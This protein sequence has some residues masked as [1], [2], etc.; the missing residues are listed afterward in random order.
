[1]TSRRRSFM[2]KDDVGFVDRLNEA[3]DRAN[4]T[5]DKLSKKLG[6]SR[7]AVGHWLTGKRTPSDSQL[8]KIAEVLHVTT[9]WLLR[10]DASAEVAMLQAPDWSF[11]P[12]LPGQRDYGNAN[13]WTVPADIATLVREAGQNSKDA[14]D[15]A[16]AAI[17]MQF[18]LIELHGAEA[19][20]FWE[21]AGW[22]RLRPHVEAAARTPGKLGRKLAAGLT[23]VSERP[24]R[25]FLLRIDDFGT[26]GLTGPEAGEGSFAAL[27]RNNLDSFKQS[28][29]AGGS[30]GL[31]KAAHWRCSDISTVFFNTVTAERQA[32]VVARSELTYHELGPTPSEHHAGPG[33]FGVEG[34]DRFAESV[35]DPE[36]ARQLHLERDTL[37]DDLRSLVASE[38]GTSILIAAFQN[39]ASEIPDDP[40][41]IAEE[42]ERELAVNFFPAIRAKKLVAIVE[43]RVGDHLRSRKIV[44]PKQY[45]PDFC[46]LYDR[47]ASGATVD[48]F[49]R[50]GDIVAVPV[51]LRLPPCKRDRGEVIR[52]GRVE[53]HATLVVSLA[54]QELGDG[55]NDGDLGNDATRARLKKALVNTVALVRGPLMVT[56]FLRK[57]GI[58]VGAR[59][60]YAALL[61]GEAAGAV[62]EN[63]YVEQ[64]LRASEPPAHDKWTY[65][66]DLREI[67]E[68]GAR[69]RLE[70]FLNRELPGA[71]RKVLRIPARDDA[72]GPEELKKLLHLG[73]GGPGPD[74]REALALLNNVVPI[75]NEGRWTVRADVMVKARNTELRI[76]PQLAI[77][78]ESGRPLPLA[79]E[80]L[81]LLRAPGVRQDGE[82]FVTDGSVSRF[83]FQGVSK[84]AGL[85][86]DPRR[87]SARIGLTVSKGGVS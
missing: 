64:F 61:A 40:A 60:F 14:A 49:E 36:L 12:P 74:P 17:V 73:G 6:V 82:S 39:P 37:P 70:E 7:P 51:S 30:F 34:N 38:N 8:R 32:R 2:K 78:A 22:E 31:G 29:S 87:C 57:E 11:P 13:I 66:D 21:A 67:Y 83:T 25:A 3:V 48:S 24:D 86:V 63:R 41:A 18:S 42:I 85:P 16:S 23:R 35:G 47:F 59:P 10:G 52:H 26:K 68:R 56:Q 5:Q 79:W 19:H 46:E 9:G 81:E 1:M 28:T 45:V 50:E 80:N 62:T 69:T 84:A 33:W 27:V 77:N 54:D 75:F 15:E 44:D 72:D 65:T 4:I 20:A 55:S 76:T 43:H 58:L 71:L 53:T